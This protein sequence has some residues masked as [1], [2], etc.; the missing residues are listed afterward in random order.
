M[1][2]FFLQ[3]KQIFLGIGILVTVTNPRH[4]LDFSKSTRI[5]RVEKQGFG[6]GT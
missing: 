1:A 4:F 2:L 3:T 6:V 5:S